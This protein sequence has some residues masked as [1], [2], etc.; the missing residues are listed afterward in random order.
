MIINLSWSKILLY[1]ILR[2]RPYQKD[3]FLVN[4]GPK[5]HFSYLIS[6]VE[7]T[8]SAINTCIDGSSFNAAFTSNENFT[9]ASFVIHWSCYSFRQTGSE[10]TLFLGKYRNN[11]HIEWHVDSDCTAI[12]LVSTHFDIHEMDWYGGDLLTISGHEFTGTLVTST[13]KVVINLILDDSS[14]V[15][16]F[17]S[18]IEQHSEEYFFVPEDNSSERRGFNVMWS[19]YE[20]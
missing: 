15:A 18:N 14:F 6:L 17:T 3:K 19:C 7:Y 16:T 13:T 8:G 2:I 5:T 11:D 9:F 20:G 1:V 12:H 10:G 4:F